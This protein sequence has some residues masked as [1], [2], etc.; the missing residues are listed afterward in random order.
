M[1][2]FIEGFSISAAQD[3]G[4]CH[5]R[6]WWPAQCVVCVALPSWLFLS[7]EPRL[8]L[9]GLF[10]CYFFEFS[11]FLSPLD[12]GLLSTQKRFLLLFLLELLLVGRL[13][14]LDESFSVGWRE[15]FTIWKLQNGKPLTVFIAMNLSS[16]FACP[17]SVC[18]LLCGLAML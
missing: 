11:G 3:L 15:V 6:L 18:L 12:S 10:T 14:P 17:G 5:S 16:T 9:T 2:D 8:R 7:F 13:V 1:M 4:L